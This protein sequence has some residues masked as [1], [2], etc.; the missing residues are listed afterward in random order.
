MIELDGRLGRRYRHDMAGLLMQSYSEVTHNFSSKLSD[1][2]SSPVLNLEI[3]GSVSCSCLTNSRFCLMIKIGAFPHSY[4]ID[5]IPC[6]THVWIFVNFSFDSLV[7]LVV[8]L[9]V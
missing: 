6:Q 2:I 3:A 4:H 8:C 1:Y 5:G 9:A 7:C